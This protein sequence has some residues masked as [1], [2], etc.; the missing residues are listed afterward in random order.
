MVI[1]FSK[2]IEFLIEVILSDL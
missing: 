2:E 1:L